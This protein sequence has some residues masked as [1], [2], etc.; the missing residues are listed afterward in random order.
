MIPRVLIIEDNADITRLMRLHLVDLPAD[1]QVANDGMAGF[2]AIG[3]STFDLIILDL[4]L[5]GKSGLEILGWLDAQGRRDRVLVLSGV[6]DLPAAL[7]QRGNHRF[8]AKPFGMAALVEQVRAFLTVDMTADAPRAYG[9]FRCGDLTIDGAK[10]QVTVSGRPIDLADAELD[11]LLLLAEQPGEP[12]TRQ[13]LRQRL[14]PAAGDA[15]YLVTQHVQRLRSKIEPDPARPA[16]I[17]GG[18][19]G[20]YALCPSSDRAP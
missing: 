15:D 1:V 7:A 18:A 17:V 13:E 16:W 11:L 9:I 12:L 8:M 4:H 2:A 14:W 3:Q 5:P 19:S 10:R 6:L 20:G